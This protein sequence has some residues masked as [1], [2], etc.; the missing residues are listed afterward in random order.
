M[1]IDSVYWFV[2]A[3]MSLPHQLVSKGTIFNNTNMTR[4]LRFTKQIFYED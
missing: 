4:F 2:K 1:Y 3:Q